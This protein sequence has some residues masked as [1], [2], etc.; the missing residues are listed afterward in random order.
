MS[1]VGLPITTSVQP[2]DDVLARSVGNETVLLDLESGIYYTLNS[3][4]A[5]V[6]SALERGQTPEQAVALVVDRYD[7]DE[8]TATADVQ[9]LLQDLLDNNLV[10]VG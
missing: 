2:K 8:A 3:V 4:A 9:E 1:S 6:W 10:V 7:V 5:T